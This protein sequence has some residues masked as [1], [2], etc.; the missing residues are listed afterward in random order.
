MESFNKAVKEKQT[1]KRGPQGNQDV[2]VD[3]K[4]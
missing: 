1:W 4:A 2:K 3:E